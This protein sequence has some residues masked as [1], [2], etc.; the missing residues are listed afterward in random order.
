LK[1]YFVNIYVFEVPSGSAV[2]NTAPINTPPP[3][4]EY[5]IFAFTL[6]GEL[7]VDVI[8]QDTS[9]NSSADVLQFYMPSSPPAT[10]CVLLVGF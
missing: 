5:D 3:Y 1:A 4:F 2:I 6:T 8:P 7:N 9:A 10:E